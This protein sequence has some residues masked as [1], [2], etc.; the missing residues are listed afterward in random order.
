ME[1][2]YWII[3]DTIIFKPEFSHSL[4]EYVEIIFQYKKILFSNSNDL[5]I[6]RDINGARNILIK[7]INKVVKPKGF[8]IS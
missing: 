2:P 8:D 7:N 3:A 6:D 5:K 1:E 4:D